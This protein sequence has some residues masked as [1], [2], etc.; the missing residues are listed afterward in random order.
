MESLTCYCRYVLNSTDRSGWI[1]VQ[2]PTLLRREAH[3]QMF[4]A[5]VKRGQT[6]ELSPTTAI[7]LLWPYE[8]WFGRPPNEC[9]LSTSQ[10]LL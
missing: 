6:A 2:V 5:S 10:S 4:L 8:K 7:N 3:G 9:V 1:H